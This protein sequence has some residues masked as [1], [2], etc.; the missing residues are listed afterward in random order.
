MS[1]VDTLIAA[2]TAVAA[3]A[4][5]IAGLYQYRRGQITKRQEVLFRLLKELNESMELSLAR[6]LLVYGYV[7][8]IKDDTKA[9]L[10]G[11]PMVENYS[12]EQL[13]FLRDPT[14]RIE[15]PRKLEIKD[16]LDKFIVFLSQVGYFIK[17]GSIGRVEILYLKYW[18]DLTLRY[19]LLRHYIDASEFPLYQMLLKELSKHDISYRR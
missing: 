8:K 12:I 11:D 6:E 13:E 7:K 17:V 18:F 1:F 9:D 16:S 5:V 4:T 2:G 14:T 15:D 10:N 3:V 19:E